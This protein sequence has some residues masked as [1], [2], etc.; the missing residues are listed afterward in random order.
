SSG[1]GVGG[2]QA[3]VV[4]GEPHPQEDLDQPRR[5]PGAPAA[6]PS[7][8][9]HAQLGPRLLAL[10]DHRTAAALPG[11]SRGTTGRGDRLPLS[12]LA[13][14]EQGRAADQGC[15]R[16]ASAA[17]GSLVMSTIELPDLPWEE[18][19]RVEQLALLPD[20]ERDLLLEDVTEADLHT[21][22]MILRPKQLAVVNSESWITAYMG[23]RG[24]GETK[25][26]ARWVN[27]RAKETP[28]CFI[29][30]LGRTVADVRDV[31]IQGES[32]ILAESDPNF[33]PV[34]TPSL[35]KLVWP[36]GSTAV[37]YT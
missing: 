23:G 27:K 24:S 2:G 30:L 29:A 31:M 33:M 18:M 17:L 34:Y 37:T 1:S 5:Q 35:R 22:E 25:T 32:G 28:G 16:A 20:E 26:G 7:T 8:R 3:G 19:S 15:A 14:V 21:D 9:T 11:R 6:P 4:G 10:A 36:N 13:L 12:V